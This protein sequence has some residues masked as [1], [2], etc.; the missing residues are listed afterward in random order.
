MN[1]SFF[2][3][4]LI[5]FAALIS[6]AQD[7]ITLDHY[8]DYEWASNPRVSPD[9]S[10]VI[11]SRSWINGVE[12][13]RETDLWIMNANGS[14]NRF[15]LKGGGGL[16]S[17]D[18]GRVA[19]VKNGEPKGTQIFVKYMGVEGEPTQITRL[20]K[21]PSNMKWSP[22]GKYI[23]FSMFVEQN[24]PWKVDLPS[25]PDGAKWTESPRF[26]D[27]VVYLMY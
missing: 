26:V 27:K 11:Y 19:F 4:A 7:K 22:D 13:K 23:A 18:G 17:P 25:K 12:D 15:F 1:R 8:L 6:N 20:E 14:Q 9:G 3:S 5:L 16:W 2:I 24:K 21:S 10:Q